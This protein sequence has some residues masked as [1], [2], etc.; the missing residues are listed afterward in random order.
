MGIVAIIVGVFTAN[1]SVAILSL[2]S[3]VI[4][5]TFKPYPFILAAIG[6]P[7]VEE[8]FFRGIILESLLKR[9][10]AFVA[11]TGLAFTVA[12]AH[13]SYWSAV[14]G[15]AVLSIF[16]IRSRHSLILSSIAHVT[17]NSILM[18]SSEIL[19]YTHYLR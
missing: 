18:S 17:C 10:S 3:K 11:V 13:D 12:F 5:E 9:Y 19:L 7:L 2:H 4:E 14:L 15:Q 16:Y 1:I 8:V 6:F